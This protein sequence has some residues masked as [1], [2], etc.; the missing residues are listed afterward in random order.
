[1]RRESQTD[2]PGERKG[3][4]DRDRE[5]DGRRGG[6]RDRQRQGSA[7]ATQEKSG[8]AGDLR[9][10][11]RQEVWSFLETRETGPYSPLDSQSTAQAQPPAPRLPGKEK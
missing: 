5:A 7:E 2:S 11:E 6:D 9:Q 1:L 3:H 10:K 4:G 8:E